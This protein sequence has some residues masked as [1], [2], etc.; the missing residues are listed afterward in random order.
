VLSLPEDG[1][2]GDIRNTTLHWKLDEWQSHKGKITSVAQILGSTTTVWRPRAWDLWTAGIIFCD[3]KSRVCPEVLNKTIVIVMKTGFT[4]NTATSDLARN[5]QACHSYV[6]FDAF[7]VSRLLTTFP[8][9]CYQDPYDMS[10]FFVHNPAVRSV[11][12]M[13]ILAQG[14][15]K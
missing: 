12:S 13:S 14:R 4:S 10:Q 8:L 9:L 7:P 5:K 1:S 15:V 6:T 3:S 2:R 11:M